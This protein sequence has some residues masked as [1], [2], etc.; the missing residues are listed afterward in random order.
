[1]SVPDIRIN[2][3]DAYEDAVKVC[4]HLKKSCR[5]RRVEPKIRELKSIPS[6]K[7]KQCSKESKSEPSKESVQLWLCLGC[8]NLFCGRYDQQHALRHY[9]REGAS[10]CLMWN[11]ESHNCWCYLCDDSIRPFGHR[12]EVLVQIQKYWDKHADSEVPRD[13]LTIESKPLNYRVISPGLQNLGNTCFFNSVIQLLASLSP[14]HEIISPHPFQERSSLEIISTSALT[15]AFTKLLGEIYQTDKEKA[16]LR[17]A[18]LFAEIRKKYPMFQRGA[19]QDAQELFHY[20]LEG[21]KTDE[22]AQTGDKPD[23]QTTQSRRRTTGEEEFEM[24][25]RTDRKEP[26]QEFRPSNYIESIFE[27]R[28]ASIVVC[29]ACNNISTTYDQ[30]EELSLSIVQ[31]RPQVKERKGR[32]RMAIG[33][34]SRRSRNSLSLTRSSTARQGSSQTSSRSR[35]K[36]LPLD[37]AYTVLHVPKGATSMSEADSEE[38]DESEDALAEK[39]LKSHNF[40]MSEAKTRLE[41]L[42]FAI[43]R[44]QSA[45]VNEPSDLNSPPPTGVSDGDNASVLLPCS[46][47]RMQYIQRLLQEPE[48]VV[49]Q[50]TIEDSLRDFTMVEC[51]EKENAFACEECA[52]LMNSSGMNVG[53]TDRAFSGISDEMDIAPS[54]ISDDTKRTSFS[55]AAP[56]EID[57][58]GEMCANIPQAAEQPLQLDDEILMARNE[59]IEQSPRM[60]K[61]IMRRAYKRFLLADLPHVLILHLKRFQQSGKSLYSSLRKND[62]LVHFE[63][64]LDLYPYLMPRPDSSVHAGSSRYRC[65]G[66]IVHI[67]TINSG[68][69]VAYFL[70]HKTVGGGEPLGF[71]PGSKER[72]WVFA[73]DA[74][75]RSCSWTEV[76]KSRA[77]MLWYERMQDD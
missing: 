39:Q 40:S 19:Q 3:E 31:E 21:L 71:E 57:E 23:L 69:Y 58:P 41:R 28:L 52:K 8:G 14:L 18:G 17:P 74:T 61:H 63:E 53:T 37:D 4:P 65:I 26:K 11:I 7:C 34:F 5:L 36:D 12:N 32:F 68:H 16:V 35:A 30:F 49:L 25:V 13:K 22:I 59:A 29:S 64:Q 60:P 43:S 33:D 76:C 56:M 47:E 50:G 2:D 62:A 55:S 73:S 66:A 6:R 77:Y 9:E 75:T 67:G 20:L 1:M 46:S 51:L 42:S 48:A 15:S 24:T 10:D 54:T 70:T 38:D 27:G 72:Q 45:V 44:R